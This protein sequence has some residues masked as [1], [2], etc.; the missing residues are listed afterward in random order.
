MKYLFLLLMLLL[1]VECEHL[2]CPET[3]NE[4]IRK[5][6][7]HYHSSVP[8]PSNFIPKSYMFLTTSI[9]DDQMGP[10]VDH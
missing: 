10:L 2:P 4:N 7:I 1:A 9:G 5:F 8:S 6:M 3:T